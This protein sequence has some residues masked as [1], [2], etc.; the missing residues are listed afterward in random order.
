MKTTT[1]HMKAPILF[2]L[3]MSTVR[4]MWKVKRH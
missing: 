4:G 1:K 3:A 2:E